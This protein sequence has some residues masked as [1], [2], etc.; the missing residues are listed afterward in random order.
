MNLFSDFLLG[1]K[2]SRMKS[3]SLAGLAVSI[4]ACGQQNID[5]RILPQN[6]IPGSFIVEM[7]ASKELAASERLRQLAK[8]ISSKHQCESFSLEPIAW[9]KSESGVL[10][11][12]LDQSLHLNFYD[13]LSSEDASLSMMEGLLDSE[14]VANA[15]ANAILKN[16]YSENDPLKNRQYYLS[17]IKRDAACEVDRSRN[18]KPVVVAI[19]DSGVERSHPDLQDKFLRDANGKIVGANFV[20]KGA[21]GQPD[22]RWDD[23]NGHGTHV[24]GLVAASS[25]NREGIAGVAACGNVKLMPIRVMGNDGSGNS[26]EIDRGIQWAAAK[27]ADIINLSLGSNSVS[28]SKAQQKKSLYEDLAKQGVIVFAA[29]GNDG[30][31]NGA[32][33]NYGGR[34]AYQYS[35]P[36]SYDKVIAVASTTSRNSLSNF[37]NRGEFIDIAAPGSDTLSTYPGRTYRSLSGTS[38]ATPV[39]AGAYALALA[40]VRSQGNERFSYETASEL[41]LSSIDSRVGFSKKEVE[42]AGVIDTSKLLSAVMAKFPKPDTSQPEEDIVDEPSDQPDQ[43]VEQTPSLPQAFSFVGLK[44]GSQLTGALDIAMT[45]WPKNT[46][47][48]EI[49]WLRGDE[50]FARPFT[51]LD[52]QNLTRDG[53]NVISFDSYLLY[54]DRYLTAVALDG[55]GRKIKQTSIF[56]R[57]L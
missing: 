57:G 17:N 46:A 39:A 50:W 37:S 44:S 18:E 41:L 11:T 28:F 6:K 22:D 32:S 14:Q 4:A 34:R 24:A 43:P 40:S 38:M 21:R 51:S 13:C 45:N 48:I 26:L 16:S 53:K 47:K 20:G 19:I 35:F 30:A 23:G 36:A 7:K 25:N 54:G 42:A 49:Y 3:M 55:Y 52:R 1:N 33:V 2:Y 27:G 10:S 12:N 9:E 29:A 15:E 8:G 5:K 56:L 31:I